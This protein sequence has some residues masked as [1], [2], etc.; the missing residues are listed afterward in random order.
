MSGPLRW[1]VL[2]SLQ[3]WRGRVGRSHD[4]VLRW[5]DGR[6][7]GVGRW[8]THCGGWKTVGSFIFRHSYFAIFQM[9]F[10]TA[11]LSFSSLILSY[12]WNSLTHFHAFP[13]FPEMIWN[14][15]TLV[16][17]IF[18]F[19]YFRR[20]LRQFDLFSSF[21]HTFPYFRKHLKQFISHFH[22]SYFSH[23]SQ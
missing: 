18:T 16:F 6:H 15:L 8:A 5:G 9:I 3:D 21:I 4:N 10:E 2:S 20:Y 19:P 17:I 22:Q 23:T 11:W 7:E 14:S 12:V 1:L 13:T